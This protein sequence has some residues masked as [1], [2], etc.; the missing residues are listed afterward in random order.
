ML[1]VPEHRGGAG[2]R[3]FR[4]FQVGRCVGSAAFFTV[5]AVLVFGAAFRARALDEAVGQEHVLFRVEILGDRTGGDVPSVTQLQVDLARQLT[6]F[7]G[8]SGEIGRAHV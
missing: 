3:R 4:V 7:F 5:V 1:G 8:V 2:N 6:V